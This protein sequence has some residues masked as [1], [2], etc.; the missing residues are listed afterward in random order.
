MKLYLV[1]HGQTASNRE[2]VGL[3]REDVALTDF[4]QLQAARLARRFAEVQVDRVVT[5]P[6]LRARQTATALAAELPLEIEPDDALLELDVGETE[7]MPFPEMREKY[8]DFLR[9]WASPDCAHVRMPG[10]ESLQDLSDRLD[11]FVEHLREAQLESLAVVSHNFTTKIL[12]CRLLGLPLAG[13]R[14]F[15]TDLASVSELD[16][17][18][19]RTEVFLLNDTCHLQNLE[20]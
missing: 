20:P 8:P 7:G 5:S 3:G 1:R 10:G 16:I 13:F 2:G 6:L 17:R 12:L 14:H 9:L 11:P 15:A 4:G 18:E 19:G